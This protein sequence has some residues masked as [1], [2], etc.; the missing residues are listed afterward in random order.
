MIKKILA[1]VMMASSL[2][3]SVSCSEDSKKHV[4]E[5]DMC[6]V[7]FALDVE[8]VLGTRAI[9]DGT[10]ANQLMWAIFDE[11]G[12][13]IIKKAVKDNVTGLTSQNGYTF[14]ITL[15]KGKTYKA[16][17]W[18][19]NSACEAYEVSDDMQ[20]TINYEGINNDESRDAFFATTKA[21]TVE[22]ET[23][24]SAVLK[25][26]FAQVNVGAYPWD[27][28]YAQE[29]G[30]NVAVSAATIKN[31]P[32]TIKLFDGSVAGETV[33]EY[34]FSAIPEESLLV[35]V[36]ED[37]NDEV[38]EYL[39]MSYILAAPESSVH[40]MV[41]TFAD[42][43]SAASAT[44]ADGLS[45]V[46]VQRN[47]RTN[48]VGQIVTGTMAFNIKIDP[49]YEGETIN[50][51]GLYYNFTEDTLIE[52]KEFA[53]NTGEGATFTSENNNVITFNNVKFSGKVEQIA[54]GEYRDKGNYVN[55]TNVL[56]NVTAENMVI[57]HGKGITNVQPLDYMAPLFFLRGVTTV[58]NSKFTGATSVAP[59]WED[60]NGDLHEVLPYDCGVP[61]FCEATFDGCT[62]SRL[63]AWSHSKITLK[64]TKVE[65]IRCSTHKKRYDS[66]LV[67]D[68][69]SEVEEIFV[70]SS[71]QQN[72]KREDGKYVLYLPEYWSPSIIIK[73][74]AKVGK[75]DFNGR[76]IEDV[77]IEEGAEIG[78][79]VNYV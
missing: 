32:N 20:V 16:T 6:E 54:I 24:V 21:F 12:E 48:I 72:V 79:M 23:V 69:G 5:A 33:V 66:Y 61:N 57:T 28:E 8:G 52:N 39:S 60:I 10:G 38:Y 18:A 19:Q 46:P 17:F 3:F 74:G 31:V 77:E 59:E 11:Q 67:I 71:N 53:F 30:L 42:M 62:I 44:F 22:S 78:E 56:N 49:V 58:K 7:K 68:A 40:E 51:A 70:T 55:F 9:S 64:N 37:G 50:S 47:W 75:I 43:D 4:P 1:G 45:T 26:P 25:R 35:D 13:L 14:S 27:L 76:T 73:A 29:S 15:A 2:L 65:Y 36:D 63:Y 34:S 41:F